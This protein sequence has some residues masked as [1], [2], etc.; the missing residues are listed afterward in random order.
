MKSLS[1]SRHALPTHIMSHLIL[2]G[3]SLIAMFDLRHHS[4]STDHTF[5]NRS[6]PKQ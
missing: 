1:H 3:Q 2:E 4:D 6:P 5:R